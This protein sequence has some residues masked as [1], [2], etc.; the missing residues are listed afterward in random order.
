[1]A[2][3]LVRAA[4]IAEDSL[5]FLALFAL[6][7]LLLANVVAQ[8]LFHTGIKDTGIYIEHLV[9][10]ATFIAASVTSREKKHLS[11]ATGM[12]LPDKLKGPAE[13]IT[14]ALA[15][16]LTLAFGLSAVS[17][18][19]NAF[20][21]DSRVGVLPKRLVVLVMAAGFL[22][23]SL[24]F[25]TTLGPRKGRAWAA[26]AAV[27]IGLFFGFAPL[28]DLASA[29]G[30]VAVPALSKAGAFLAPLVARAAG[31]MI[32]VLIAAAFLGLPIFA[33]LGGI[34]FLLFAKT[35]Q[36][37]EIIP[38]QAY[39]VL[40]GDA[41]PAIPLF[42]AV[43]FFLSES[44]A[45]QRLVAFF[46]AM[47]GWFPGGLILMAVLVC[48]FFTTFTGASG[49]TILAL[50][51]LLAIIL[52]KAGYPKRFNVG[53]LTASGS[54]GLLFP[55]SLPV[56]IYGVISQTSIKDMFIGGALPGLF[57]VVS[58]VTVGIVY[59]LRRRMP[60]HPLR[61]GAAVA[62]LGRSFWELLL[63]LLVFGLYFG[64]ILSLQE[65]AAASLLYVWIVETFIK[66]DLR[67]RDLPGIFLRAV[68]IIGGVLIIL[69][70]ANGL[71]YYIIDAQ[72]PLKLSAW[73]S[74][75]ISSPY[76]FLLLLNLALI[77]VG[78]FMDIYSAILVVVP[79]II[80]LGAHF[81][82]NPVHLGIIF[83]AN[84]ELGYLT[85]PVGL[86]LYL[87]SYR[88]EEPI[89]R[90]YRDVL[91]F[92]GIGLVAVL[93]ITYVPFLTMALLK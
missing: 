30:T 41:V 92:L 19:W 77:V 11:L 33:V 72:I 50:G 53:L 23:M 39:T 79:L 6:A 74:A 44:K 62:A 89:H 73:I 21:A 31:P 63:P 91:I 78:C 20:T 15:S 27:L 26:V 29:G 58:V 80:P 65:S 32:F 54:I 28:V 59:S 3:R 2:N 61:I 86:N 85:P 60:R 22:A 4:H 37:L 69:A 17:F 34:G 56:I 64:G 5:A 67:I 81:H 93:L 7:A 8:R 70:L 51:G 10:A 57:L 40:T 43:G 66:R 18:A 87:A 47:F 55:P 48:A 45:G 68:P 76:V 38:N 52:E 46:Q 25:V 35:G 82:I 49:V 14:A 88:F 36:P 16:G 83:L 9:L 75:K 13:A 90:V 42:A 12:F 24:R 71:S 84:L 1:M